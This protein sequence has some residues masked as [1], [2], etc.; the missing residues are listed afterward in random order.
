M[1]K[2]SSSVSGLFTNVDRG[3]VEQG[4]V[5]AVG[6]GAA[7]AFLYYAFAPSS[8]GYKRKPSTFELSGGTIDKKEIKAKFD[9]YAQSYGT[10]FAGSC[11]FFL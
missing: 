6:I 9:D 8:S 3:K 11:N 4:V 7:A 10:S 1:D 2:I 5:V